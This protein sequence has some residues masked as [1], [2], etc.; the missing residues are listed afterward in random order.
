MK[1]GVTL[2]STGQSLKVVELCVG[3]LERVASL[4]DM[5]SSVIVASLKGRLAEF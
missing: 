1:F 2:T 3:L 4:E 5:A